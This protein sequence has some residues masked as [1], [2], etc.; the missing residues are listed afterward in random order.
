MR[1]LPQWRS[2]VLANPNTTSEGEALRMW[3]HE[4]ERRASGEETTSEKKKRREKKHRTPPHVSAQA[5]LQ[6]NAK[7]NARVSMQTPAAPVSTLQL[8]NTICQLWRPQ[9]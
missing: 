3:L 4:R 7:E 6:E 5:E 2:S 8:P 1:E 9:D